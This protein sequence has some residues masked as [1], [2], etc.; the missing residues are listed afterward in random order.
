LSLGSMALHH[1]DMGMCSWKQGGVTPR[2]A[3]V[4]TIPQLT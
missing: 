1:I 2:G 4:D 3:H